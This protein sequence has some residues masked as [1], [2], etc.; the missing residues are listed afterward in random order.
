MEEDKSY[1][2]GHF[3]FGYILGKASA[4]FTKTGINIP[5]IFVLSVL[6]DVDIIIGQIFPFFYHRGPLHSIIVLSVLFIPVFAIYRVRAVPYF[7]AL[8]QHPLLGDFLTAGPVQLLWP[9]SRSYYG[10]LTDIES[11]VNVSLEWVGFAVMLVTMAKTKDIARFLH[12]HNSN[13]ILAI[14]TF[15]V[16]LPTFLSFPLDV[17]VWLVPPHLFFIVLFLVAMLIGV[18]GLSLSVLKRQIVELF[19]LAK[20]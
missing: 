2:V 7:L 19:S 11:P 3:A 9:V 5:V 10:I 14:P 12:A 8:I 6:P 16:L 18:C 1:A 13:L 17:P 20:R 15:T 4:K